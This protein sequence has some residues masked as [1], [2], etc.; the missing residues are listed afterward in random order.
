[1]PPVSSNDP[2]PA[3]KR[4]TLALRVL[5]IEVP[6][7]TVDTEALKSYKRR[8]LLAH[9]PDKTEAPRYTIRVIPLP[10]LELS[11]DVV[12]ATIELHVEPNTFVVLGVVALSRVVSACG[13]PQIRLL[14][15]IFRGGMMR[16]VVLATCRK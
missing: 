3:S 4:K 11:G 2:S 12:Y 15:R 14:F 10:D 7:E 16:V 8:A 13:P 5:A 9:H 1:M 6:L